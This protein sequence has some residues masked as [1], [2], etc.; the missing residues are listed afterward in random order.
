MC[1][2]CCWRT[3]P[4]GAT[5]DRIDHFFAGWRS[6]AKSAI[7]KHQRRL[8]CVTVGLSTYYTHIIWI[9]ACCRR[10]KFCRCKNWGLVWPLVK[11]ATDGLVV[12]TRRPILCFI[13][14]KDL[15]IQHCKRGTKRAGA[16][17]QQMLGDVF[18]LNMTISWMSLSDYTVSK[19][20]KWKQCHHRWMH[21]LWSVPVIDIYSYSFFSCPLCCK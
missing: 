13:R 8:N 7:S 9:F 2:R 21:R 20:R 5:I 11:K 12:A 14:W 19:Q 15:G 16:K 10:V 1:R 18:V 17:T 3:F 4:T 6:A